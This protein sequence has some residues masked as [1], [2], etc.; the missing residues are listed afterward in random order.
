VRLHTLVVH[1]EAGWQRQGTLEDLAF[2]GA[3]LVVDEPLAGGDAISVSFSAP[4][5][6]DPLS[7]RARV[8][9]VAPDRAGGNASRAGVAFEHSGGDAV[10]AL[11][12][13]LSTLGAGE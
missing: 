7:L 8:V 4:T 1:L 11:Y 13:V 12:E 9:W 6:W 10:F 5:L 2:G 3:R